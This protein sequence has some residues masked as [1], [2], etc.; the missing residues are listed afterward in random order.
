[1][2]DIFNI[3]RKNIE[4]FL[5]KKCFLKRKKAHLSKTN[6]LFVTLRI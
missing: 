1:M 4:A 6:S 3:W 2:S 5:P